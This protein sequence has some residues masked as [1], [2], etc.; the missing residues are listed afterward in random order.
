MG[1][2]YPEIEIKKILASVFEVSAEDINEQSSPDTLA[3][4]DSMH[5]MRLIVDLEEAFEITFTDEQVVNMV[6][7]PS[8]K[9]A[10]CEYD[11]KFN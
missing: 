4:W 9:T 1:K 7:Y 3:K 2:T 11:I 5:K 6:D 10:V 8:V